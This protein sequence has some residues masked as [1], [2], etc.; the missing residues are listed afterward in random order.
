MQKLRIELLQGRRF[1]DVPIGEVFLY[2]N[3][4]YI[5]L[6]DD[7]NFNC[8]KFFSKGTGSMSRQTCVIVP[9]EIIIK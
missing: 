6:N 8:K 9:E 2:T 4:P 5:K 3:C 1:E 7:L